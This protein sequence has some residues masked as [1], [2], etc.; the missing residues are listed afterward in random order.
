MRGTRKDYAHFISIARGS[1]A[2]TETFLLLIQRL[3]LISD[4]ETESALT[5]AANVGRMLT[6]LRQRLSTPKLS[7]PTLTT[8]P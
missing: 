6:T 7:K 2:E 5:Q 3:K 4:S 8:S 1:V